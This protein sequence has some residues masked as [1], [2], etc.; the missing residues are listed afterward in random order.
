[1]PAG[2]LTLLRIFDRR[3]PANGRFVTGKKRAKPL[4]YI[5]LTDNPENRV[6]APGCT[7]VHV[8]AM[9]HERRE[10]SFVQC[11]SPCFGVDFFGAT[12]AGAFAS[13]PCNC[14]RMALAACAA[15]AASRRA[16][17]ATRLCAAASFFA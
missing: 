11:P 14:E 8:R 10:T 7:D 13:S 5:H 12:G 2:D 17:L 4:F 1:M 3:K 15:N 6:S 16:D 9:H